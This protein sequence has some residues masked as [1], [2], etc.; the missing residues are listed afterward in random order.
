MP[1]AKAHH[2]ELT[3]RL[4][5]SAFGWK[6]QPAIQRVRQAVSEIKKVAR[7]RRN[8]LRIGP[9]IWGGRR[10]VKGVAARWEGAEP[11]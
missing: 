5:R 9:S 10:G 3:S 11:G 8:F 1:R 7:H 4:R 6:S 2:W